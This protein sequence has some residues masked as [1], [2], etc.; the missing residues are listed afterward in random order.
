[1]RPVTHHAV[2][3]GDADA[4]VAFR[5]GRGC[6]CGVARCAPGGRRAVRAG[7]SLRRR[8]APRT[9]AELLEQ[10][11]YAC[12]VT[13]EFD[14]ALA[15]QERAVLMLGEGDDPR[16]E[17]RCAAL[18]F[19][20][21]PL[22][23]PARDAMEVAPPG[24]RSARAAPARPRARARVLQSLAPLH[25]RGGPG[26]D[27]RLGNACA[28]ARE[29][30]DDIEPLIYALTNI[31]A[32][33]LNFGE[34]DGTESS[35]RASTSPSRPDSEEHAGRAYVNLVWW[36]PRSR[37]YAAA[38][39]YLEAG[40]EYCSERGLDLWRAYLLA[41]RA[42][43]ELDRGRW[44]DAAESATL[45]LRDPRTSPVP[46]TVALAVVGMVRARR[47]DPDVWPCSTR[48]GRSRPTPA[49]CSASS[50]PRRPGPRPPG[51]RAGED[52]SSTLAALELAS[53]RGRLGDRR[54][55]EWRLRAGSVE[56]AV[57]RGGRAVCRAACGRLAPC[58]RAVDELG[59]PVRGGA[60]AGRSR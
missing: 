2:A 23:R 6:A 40:L 60:R 33:E 38:D 20:A 28:R 8:P 10:R 46:R 7:A 53:R 57:W 59:L 11:S 39:R 25:E 29:R 17:G 34:A 9:L 48:R 21:A 37:A 16:S 3:A 4:V 52:A 50:P 42:R 49:S 1:M 41:Y 13:G 45:V 44:D 18:A 19:A 54:A 24:R 47:G 36:A 15:A 43:S 31:G 51:S 30:L 32:V 56:E 35:S 22:R 12:Y 26:G 27:T 58:R 14:E 5:A 55:C